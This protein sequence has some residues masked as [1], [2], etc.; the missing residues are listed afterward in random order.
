M[1]PIQQ[2]E[3]KSIIVR[4]IIKEVEKEVIRE[5]EKEII[6]EIE[7]ETKLYTCTLKPII[8]LSAKSHTS[9]SYTSEI[10]SPTI[11]SYTT[12]QVYN[13]LVKPNVVLEIAQQA[14]YRSLRTDLIENEPLVKPL[15]VLQQFSKS[16]RPREEI[17]THVEIKSEKAVS[18]DSEG[19]A[20]HVTVP[21]LLISDS[22][23]ES[24]E[25]YEDVL[26]ESIKSPRDVI[27][28]FQGAIYF[29]DS[30]DLH[31]VKYKPFVTIEKHE[32]GQVGQYTITD[33][34]IDYEKV[35]SITQ[36]ITSQASSE[37][38]VSD[39]DLPQQAKRTVELS[40][41]I[42]LFKP[43]TLLTSFLDKDEKAGSITDSSVED[44][45]FVF[46]PKHTTIVEMAELSDS[47]VSDEEGEQEIR[48]GVVV[49]ESKVKIQYNSYEPLRKTR[50]PLKISYERSELADFDADKSIFT[51]ANKPILMLAQYLVTSEGSE[52]DGKSESSEEYGI[53]ETTYNFLPVSKPSLII[54]KAVPENL[55]VY[56]ARFLSV[57][58]G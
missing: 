54:Q 9:S 39:D 47:S 57:G 4:E 19:E 20:V 34:S 42:A 50:I 31:I 51:I 55:R 24:E 16:E 41:N 29:P 27:S 44:E 35:I 45:S 15:S 17:I 3:G 8:H 32:I 1:I 23:V 12:L 10:E 37:H 14:L 21:R 26:V 52:S 6:K 13:A 56:L 5:V 53:Q 48:S 58:E 18:S 33:E 2:T 49:R 22:S 36:D 28:R 38:S 7:K 46:E 30:G 11:S 43:R 40:H 25:S